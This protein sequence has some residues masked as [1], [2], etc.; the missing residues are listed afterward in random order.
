MADT[1]SVTE[2]IKDLIVHLHRG[3]TGQAETILRDVTGSLTKMMQ[4]ESDATSLHRAQQTMF[5]F[6]EVRI[7]LGERNFRGAAD[8]ARDAGKEWKQKQE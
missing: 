5:A 6:E 3:N 4:A 2:G 8:A 7:M 1:L